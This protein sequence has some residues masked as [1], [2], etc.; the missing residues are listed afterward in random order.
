MKNIIICLIT[1]AIFSGCARDLKVNSNTS[2]KDKYG[3]ISVSTEAKKQLAKEESNNS[4]E[5]NVTCNRTPKTGSRIRTV[6]C[7][8][9]AEFKRD[10]KKSQDAIRNE[11][12]RANRNIRIN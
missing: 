11:R 9:V 12:D 1:L 6:S 10:R 7:K 2:M 5:T 4:K 8:T 3:A